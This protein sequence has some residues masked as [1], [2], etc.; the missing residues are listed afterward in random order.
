MFKVSKNISESL[1]LLNW[2]ASP[3]AE[4]FYPSTVFPSKISIWQE[5]FD[6]LWPLET[7]QISKDI[8]TGRMRLN[9]ATDSID[10]LIDRCHVQ[11]YSGQLTEIIR[12]LFAVKPDKFIEILSNRLIKIVLS[13]FCPNE[14]LRQEYSQELLDLCSYTHDTP[15]LQS[16]KYNLNQTDDNCSAVSD[17][18]FG[19]RNVFKSLKSE[20]DQEKI[21]KLFNELEIITKKWSRAFNDQVRENY[22]PIAALKLKLKALI[23]LNYFEDALQ[24]I[25]RFTNDDLLDDLIFEPVLTLFESTSELSRV[26]SLIESKLMQIDPES[27]QLILRLVDNLIEAQMYHEASEYLQAIPE[28]YPHLDTVTEARL[29]FASGLCSWHTGD[30]SKST[31]AYFLNSAKLN[32]LQ[33]NYFEW[34][35]KFYWR[36]EK[37]SG[38]ALKCFT[39]AL[40][41]DPLNLPAAILFSEVTLETK[42]D[43]GFDTIIQ[44]LRPFTKI[45]KQSRNRRLF[46]YLAIALFKTK[47]YLDA[48]VSF[49]SALK[50]SLALYHEDAIDP[51]ISDENC[52]QWLGEAYSRSNRLGSA[53][54]TFTRLAAIS[55]DTN[56][57]AYITAQVGLAT[58]HL[59]SNNPIEAVDCLNGINSIEPKVNLEKAK[60]FLA[61]A[62]L[63]L[64]QGRFISAMRATLNSLKIGPLKTAEG[65]RI[66]SD[67]LCLAHKHR[68]MTAFPSK[69]FASLDFGDSQ[70]N[71][72]L[73]GISDSI[74]DFDSL[75]GKSVRLALAGISEAFKD[76]KKYSLPSFWL[77]LAVS[78]SAIDSDHLQDFIMS[79][80]S[81]AVKEIDSSPAIKSQGHQIQALIYAKTPGTYQLAQH[82]FISALKHFESSR[83]WTDLGRF[84]LKAGDWELARDSFKRALTVDQEDLVA[85]FELARSSGTVEGNEAALQVAQRA[86]TQQPVYFTE[87]FA[88]F[89]ISTTDSQSSLSKYATV[90]LKRFY[91]N[92]P[93][94]QQTN[95]LHIPNFSSKMGLL[96]Y[97][98]ESESPEIWFYPE[99]SEFDCEFLLKRPENEVT[100]S[101]WRAVV[102]GLLPITKE[103]TKIELE[104]LK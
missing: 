30:H 49:Q 37:E 81:N 25:S 26:I 44:L 74:K 76:P 63:Y 79:A 17:D 23:A 24:L 43:D 102:E 31:L 16:I 3:E 64:R 15:I 4:S 78:L 20:E 41:L 57:S 22:D 94:S 35:G 89:L 72:G 36:I 11:N 98:N 39:K 87:D 59:I 65:L 46:Y 12:N 82:H 96:N 10:R 6:L 21:L 60:S 51:S 14:Q 28:A 19:P 91:F 47:N 71:S 93:V 42:A 58:V 38:R 62:R 7:A 48:A 83:L 92:F 27:P 85:A 2:L 29:S 56:S 90:Y 103:R 1:K 13:D 8:E 95:T 5:Q 80:A 18:L 32:P 34:I 50:G 86:F 45:S 68:E 70:I 55:T 97:L 104:E 67:S 53:A 101:G 52:L 88:K 66:A 84:Y 77:Q 33:S 75:A 40:N 61:L 54:K 100:Q 73:Q 99:A 9:S 69:E